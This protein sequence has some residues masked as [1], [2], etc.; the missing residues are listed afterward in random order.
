VYGDIFALIASKLKLGV[1]MPDF[2]GV[3]GLMIGNDDSAT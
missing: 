2:K 3:S 1:N